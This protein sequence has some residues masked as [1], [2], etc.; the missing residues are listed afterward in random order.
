MGILDFIKKIFTNNKKNPKLIVTKLVKTYGS[1][2]KFE[3]GLYDE[4]TPLKDMIFKYIT[5]I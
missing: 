4:K 1:D 5:W 3:V 2:E